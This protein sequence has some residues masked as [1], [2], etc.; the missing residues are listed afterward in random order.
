MNVVEAL[1][2]GYRRTASRTGA[3]L[4]L[5]AF[6]A[7]LAST[8]ALHSQPPEATALVREEFPALAPPADSPLSLPMSALGA[9]ALSFAATVA[10]VAVFVVGFRALSEEG[11]PSPGTV[12]RNAG[13]ATLHG[14]VGYLLLLA[15]TGVG[16][17]LFL[18][19]G[20]FVLVSFAFFVGFVA[21]EDE[22]VL[23]AY[24]ESW[25]LT[26][27]RRLGVALLFGA[28]AAVVLIG[29]A[30][31]GVPVTLLFGVSETLG[32]IANVAVSAVTLVYTAAVL[33]VGFTQLRDGDEE[34][35]DEFSDIDDE[36][37]P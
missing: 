11:I 18:L 26:S 21:L 2:T 9:S 6:V 12:T 23:S 15:L 13:R 37:L 25:A 3:G 8:V 22:G 17:A 34:D 7:Q 32:W 36:L 14:V 16:L 19:P 1:R 10:A 24:R 27:G 33:A 30:L 5:A 4:V 28:L 35:D 31:A 29:S 20:V